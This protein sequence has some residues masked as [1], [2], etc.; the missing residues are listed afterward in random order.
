MKNGIKHVT[1]LVYNIAAAELQKTQSD[2]L[3][4]PSV[5]VKVSIFGLLIPD[6]PLQCFKEPKN[7]SSKCESQ[8][9]EK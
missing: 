5:A 9:Q 3:Y 1:E 6:T 8:N 7:R 4:S 2:V